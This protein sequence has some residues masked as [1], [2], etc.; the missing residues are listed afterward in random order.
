M[1]P[2]KQQHVHKYQRMPYS[3]R[4]D[5]EKEFIIYKCIRIGCRHYLDARLILNMPTLC[6]NC[7]REIIIDQRMVSQKIVKPICMFCQD[8]RKR[9]RKLKKEKESEVN[10]A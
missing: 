4:L 10:L 2:K 7:E 1:I 3:K 5:P 6:H 9:E 8:E